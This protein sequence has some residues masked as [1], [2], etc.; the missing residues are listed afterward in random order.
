MDI[1]PDMSSILCIQS[2]WPTCHWKSILCIQ[3]N[4]GNPWTIHGSCPGVILHVCGLASY[5]GIRT[6][7]SGTRLVCGYNLPCH[8]KSILCIQ[9]NFGNPWTIH[10]SCPGVILHVCGYNPPCHWKSILC[11]Q[12]IT[13]VI[14]GSCPGVIIIIIPPSQSILCIYAK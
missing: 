9:S 8:W 3:S 13:L 14:H 12:S 7:A 2:I 1:N 6:P 4:F 11:I 5:P 10:G